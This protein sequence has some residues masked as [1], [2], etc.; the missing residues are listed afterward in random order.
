M[1]KVYGSVLWFS[2]QHLHLIHFRNNG[3]ENHEKRNHFLS[4]YLHFAFL[5]FF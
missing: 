3:G 2:H 4:K 5:I 1:M